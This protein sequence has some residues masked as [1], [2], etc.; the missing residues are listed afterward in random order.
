MT[1]SISPLSASAPPGPV[2]ST[3]PTSGCRTSRVDR[4]GRGPLQGDAELV[5]ASTLEFTQDVSVLLFV[6]NITVISSIVFGLTLYLL[7]QREAAMNALR[8]AKERIDGL[9][10]EV[11]DARKLGQYTLIAKLGEGGMGAVYRASHAM[12]RRPTAIKLVP[13]DKAGDDK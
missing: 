5:A 8:T 3:P 13:A 2:D 11:E 7:V 1:A 6:V 9:R 12:L 4:A 10:Q